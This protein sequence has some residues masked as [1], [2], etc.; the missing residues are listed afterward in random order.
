[1]T[2]EEVAGDWFDRIYAPA[3]AALRRERVPE[4]Y[5]YKTDADL[6]LW[7]HQQRRRLLVEDATADYNKAAEAVREHPLGWWRQR[8]VRRDRSAPL[9][10]RRL[11]G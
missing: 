7:V 11:R 5:S 10:E 9:P 6:F 4:A 1:M 8:E 3:V 2:R